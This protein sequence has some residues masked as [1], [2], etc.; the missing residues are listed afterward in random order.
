MR[1][2]SASL[3]LAELEELTKQGHLTPLQ[4]VQLLVCYHEFL[5]LLLQY[6][7]QDEQKTEG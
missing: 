7:R 6:L 4:H 5:D 2:A 1:Q 3:M